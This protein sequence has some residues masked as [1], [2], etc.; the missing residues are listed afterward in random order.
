MLTIVISLVIGLALLKLMLEFGET[1]LAAL[2]CILI[3]LCILSG[4]LENPFNSKY[5]PKEKI[6][7]IPLVSL[8]NSTENVGFYV[9]LS[10]NNVY[11][12]R[13]KVDS[14]FGTE[15]SNNYVTR[16]LS[17]SNIIESEDPNCTSPAL[18]IFKRKAK[19]TIWSFGLLDSETT[20]VFYVPEG[21]ISKETKLK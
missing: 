2:T 16:T 1:H 19:I 21:T 8:S 6:G 11:S 20:Y 13:Y 9:Q 15:T 12:Y 14:E 4:I 17:G 18:Q 5:Q 10:T 3:L 7:E